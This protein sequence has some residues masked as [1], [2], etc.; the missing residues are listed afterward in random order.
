MHPARWFQV[1]AKP[2]TAGDQKS[3]SLMFSGVKVKVS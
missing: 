1:D 3:K 2:V